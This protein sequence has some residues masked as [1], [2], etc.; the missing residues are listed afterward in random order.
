MFYN[1]L[2]FYRRVFQN[3]NLTYLWVGQ[4]ISQIGDSVYQIGLIW[5]TLELSGSE[6]ITGL[7][8]MSAYLPAVFLSIFSG[9]V[10]DRYDRRKIMISAD[11]FRCVFILLIPLS[12]V[13]GMLN[14]ILL[15]INAFAIAIAATFFNPARDSI[16]PTIVER[17]GLL[18]ANSLIQTSWQFSLLI[19]PAIAGGLLHFVGNVHLFTVDSLA[20]LLSFLFVFLIRPSAPEI[21]IPRKRPG[22]SEVKEGLIYA[23]KHPVILPLLLITIADNIFIMGPAIVGTPVFV[24]QV[25]GLG[26]ESYALIQACYAIGMLIG[27]A[28]LLIFGKRFKKGRILLL[29]MFLDGITFV[30]LY[31]VDSLL[32]MEI[33]IIVHSL[34]IPMLTVVRAS[35]IQEII[36]TKMT[37]RIFALVNLAVVGMS[38]VS[39]GLSGFLLEIV[40]APTLFLLIGC[41]GAICGVLGWIF[42]RD[43]REQP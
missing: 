20:Y 5:L 26:A 39:S 1:G 18:R 15:G 28:G 41:G 17:K 3:R 30:P 32:T 8:A 40:G 25:L 36:P 31:F 12:F 13:V 23:V 16:I 10:S 7:V 24:K 29:G 34:A 22:F 38:A 14:P 21:D 35:I 6:S 27:T 43:L 19:G 11:L 33:T 42:A 2:M 9:V 37:G 4:V